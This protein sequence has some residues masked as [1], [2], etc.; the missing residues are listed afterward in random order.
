MPKNIGIIALLVAFGLCG[1]SILS[2]FRKDRLIED[3]EIRTRLVAPDSPV[4]SLSGHFSL[5]MKSGEHQGVK[6]FW[7]SVISLSDNREV[8]IS[9]EFYRFRDTSFL[10]WEDNDVI[11]LYSGDSGTFFWVK[12]NSTWIKKVYSENKDDVEIPPLLKQLRPN[13]FK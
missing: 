11:W 7:V 1:I 6:G 4:T 10:F 8:F 13:V 9:E 3:D 12:E 2:F 5:N